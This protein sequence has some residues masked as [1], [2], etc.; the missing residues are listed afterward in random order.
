[1][2]EAAEQRQFRR[3]VN[4]IP[5]TE[6]TDEKSFRKQHLRVA[7][8]CRVSTDKEEQLSSYK[9]QIEYYTTKIAANPDW[10]FTR[11]YADEGISGTSVKKRKEFLNMIRAGEQERIDLILVKSVSRFGRNTLDGLN[12]VRRLKKHGVG[13]Y[14]EKENVN[15]LYMDNEMILTFFFTQ[16]QAESES[17]STNVSWGHRKNFRDGKVY[18][19]YA[20]FFGYKKGADGLPEI[21]PE[22]AA[23]VRRIFSRYLLGQS[24]R[25]IAR[26]LMA[27][28]VRSAQGRE[29]WN[30]SVIQ[31][32]LRNEKYI[33]D[34]LLQ[35]TYVADLFEHR[36][37]KN[38]GQLPKYYVEDCHPAIIDRQTFQKVQ[39]EIA[40]RASLR[41]ISPK[42]KTELA[43]YSG[44]YAF[45]QILVC[46]ECGSQYRRTVWVKNGENHP[47]WRCINRLYHGKRI[48]K[49][50]PT[51]DEDKLQRIVADAMGERVSRQAVKKALEDSIAAALAGEEGALSLPAVEV[52]IRRL[53]ERQMEL[54]QLA[55]GAGVDCQDYD[56]EIRQV[57]VAKTKL[58]AR[59]AELEK[60]QQAGT[61]FD[62][63]MDQI[64]AALEDFP[65]TI[66]YDD[67]LVR[68]M[69]STITVVDKEK[70]LLRFK[71]GTEAER[72]L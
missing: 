11:L 67:L 70:L 12:Y 62:R 60:E 19:H 34:A 71:D 56:E 32:M 1:M 5:P 10:T 3:K 40:R 9:A 35:K 39:E 4:I 15:T 65:V 2:S 26:D 23:V 68:Q 17:L 27:D 18:Y 30:D 16:A 63:R 51:L 58:L 64:S 72:M 43:K 45:S 42:S 38:T 21:V 29:V 46:G 57:T 53:Q 61:P 44:K 8:Y 22:E 66:A 14:F 36:T 33:G 13:V 54:F 49:C 55:A 37:V 41:K 52:Q 6:P 7:A 20:T 31:N 69:V 24:V 59:K 47:V 48:C 50:S 25:Q 28:G